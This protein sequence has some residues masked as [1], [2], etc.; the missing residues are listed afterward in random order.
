M[1]SEAIQWTF[2]IPLL[3]FLSISCTF[4]KS[5]M[6]RWFC[7]IRR[8]SFGKYWFTELQTSSECWYTAHDTIPDDHIYECHRWSLPKTLWILGN[9]Q[10]HGD[11]YCCNFSKILVFTWKLKSYHWQ[12]MLSVV[13]SCLKWQSHLVHFWNNVCQIPKC[14]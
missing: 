5:F 4:T 13:F 10:G 12:Q 3:K 11:M 1:E 2:C 6:H 9:C 7:N 14:E 8:W